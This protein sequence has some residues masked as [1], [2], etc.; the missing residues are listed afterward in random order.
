MQNIKPLIGAIRW[1]AWFPGN[2][3]SQPEEK[4]NVGR[5]VA[6]T[7]SQPQ[8]YFRLPYF[9]RLSQDGTA[10][11]PP[12]TQALFDAEMAYAADA[13]IDYFAYCMY[14]DNSEMAYARHF[15]EK[16]ALGEQ[17]KMCAILTAGPYKIQKHIKHLVHYFQQD[18]YQ[19]VCGGRP[20]VYFFGWL[21]DTAE[22]IRLL[23]EGCEKAGVPKPYLAA[24]F[25]NCD[26]EKAQYFDAVSGYAVGGKD[27]E[28][29]ADLTARARAR[30]EDAR[31]KEQ[32]LIPLV[33][34]GWD[35]RPR[36]ERPVSWM[37]VSADSW[38]QTA[39]PE[40]IAR[41]LQ[42]TLDYMGHH[43]ELCPANTLIIYAWNE[44]D[45]GGWLVPTARCDDKGQPIRLENGALLPS[46]ARLLAIK[47]ILK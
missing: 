23:L 3:P 4:P 12:P 34:A 8:Y 20:L 11:Y 18:Y 6:E 17:V 45:E 43:R 31:L 28:S 9:A 15:H 16:S 39:R 42:E 24:M 36:H 1:D 30:W 26:D 47:K 19:K 13:G 29:Y 2:T 37:T 14:E 7:L 44:N 35:P 22:C 5:Q 46:F 32:K 25:W 21:K 27:G 38:A 33:T 41:H 10:S 40:E